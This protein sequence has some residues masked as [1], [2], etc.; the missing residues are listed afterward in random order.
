MTVQ[1]ILLALASSIRPTSLAAVYAFLSADAPRRLM[2]VYVA[3]GLTFTLAFGLLAI[4]VFSGIEVS[5]GTSHTKG[6]ADMV[7][8]VLL[9]RSHSG[10]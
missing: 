2:A 7:G 8:G 9:S 10:C 4:A 1:I 3:A 5:A 6:I